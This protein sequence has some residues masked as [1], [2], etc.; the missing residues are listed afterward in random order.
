MKGAGSKMHYSAAN[1]PLG[2]AEHSMKVNTAEVNTACGLL[3]CMHD[4]GCGGR[5]EPSSV[6]ATMLDV[7]HG[8]LRHGINRGQR[9]RLRTCR[10]RAES[11]G[12][13]AG[14][15]DRRCFVNHSAEY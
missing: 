9:I 1:R 3:L 5:T 6:A 14:R 12:D 15:P 10:K 13:A 11:I 7:E 2:A 8:S 4:G